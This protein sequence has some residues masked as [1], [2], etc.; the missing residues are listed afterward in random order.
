MERESKAIRQELVALRSVLSA[1]G[2][3]KMK[4]DEAIPWANPTPDATSGSTCPFLIGFRDSAVGNQVLTYLSQ[5]HLRTCSYAHH[6][7]TGE[8]M[9]STPGKIKREVWVKNFS[10]NGT[11]ICSFRPTEQEEKAILDSLKL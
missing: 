2:I 5:V 8:E 7:I 10:E 1:H 4:P 9:K 3:G 11:P 6:H